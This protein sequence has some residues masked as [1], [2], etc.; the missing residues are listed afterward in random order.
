MGKPG[1][2]KGTLS[3]RLVTDFGFVHL[4]SGDMLRSHLSEG[5]DLGKEAEKYMN[6]GDLVPS[7]IMTQMVVDVVDNTLESSDKVLLDGFPRTLS[8]AQALEDHINIDFVFDLKVPNEEIVK[9]LSDR[10][11]HLPSGRVYSYA[12]NPPKVEGK[13]D[14][15]GEPLSRRKDD[16]PESIYHR[17]EIYEEKTAPVISHYEDR[18]QHFTG[19]DYPELLKEDRR[20]DAIYNSL[21]PFLEVNLPK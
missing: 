7:S 5:T 6:A 1:G 16:E 19:E 9:R 18:I 11:F 10:W 8:Q 17:L 2:G 14:V 3:K 12:F 20:S 13:D 21:K 15:T 4:S